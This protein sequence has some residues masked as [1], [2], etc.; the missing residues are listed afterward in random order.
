MVLAHLCYA[1]GMDFV[2]A[3]CNFQ[4]RDA[5]SD[6]DEV[7]VRELATSLGKKILVTRFSTMEY[8]IRHKSTV[9]IAARE[10]RYA[11]FSGLMEEHGLKTLVTAHHADDSLETFLINLSRGTGLEGLLGIPAKTDTISRPLLVFSRDEIMGYAKDQNLAWRED[12]SNADTKYVRNNIRH[13]IVPYLKELHPTFLDNFLRTQQHLADTATLTQTHIRQIRQQLFVIEGN[14]EKV[15]VSSLLDLE[16]TKTYLFHFFKDYGFTQWDDVY[17]LL[18]ANSGKEVH[19]GTHR[20][21]RDR[22]YLMLKESSGND[23]LVYP[24]MEN[25]GVM[26]APIRLKLEQVDSLGETFPNILYVDKETLKYPLLVRKWEKG[27]Y[28]Y[29]FGMKGRKKVSKF[30]KDS[31][32]DTFSKEGQWLLCSD[33]KIVWVIGK[34]PDDRFKVRDRTTKILRITW[35]R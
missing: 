6:K 17:G 11:W 24:I 34:R 4:L 12:A 30:F 21:L 5:E 13:N 16:P 3:H 33:N 15:K 35:E 31:K 29:P 18:T 9:Q 28:F 20:L 23:R 7:F 25:Q 2:V 1:C 22:E 27:D 19:S 14:V 10:L 32:M 8:V 26:D